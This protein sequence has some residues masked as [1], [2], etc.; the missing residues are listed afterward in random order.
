MDELKLLGGCLY[1]P[2]FLPQQYIALCKDYRDAVRLAWV[3][4]RSK[5]MLH[6]T[7]AE[8]AELYAS[9]VSEYLADKP[10]NENGKKYRNLPAEKIDLFEAAV[11][12]KVIT[13]WKVQTAGLTIMEE[14]IAQRA[15]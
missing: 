10:V 1:G 12:N 9:H 14:V 13:Q 11:G 8:R 7:L 4:R 15:A 6:R 5:G 2:G 3:A